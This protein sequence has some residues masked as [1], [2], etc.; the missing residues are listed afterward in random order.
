V[1]IFDTLSVPSGT[2]LMYGTLNTARTVLPGDDIIIGA[3][4][5]AEAPF[6]NSAAMSAPVVAVAVR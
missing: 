2:L 6:S 1:L 4:V 5:G 3:G